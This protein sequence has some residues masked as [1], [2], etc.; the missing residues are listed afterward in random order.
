MYKPK[1]AS[2]CC[3]SDYELQE[4][5]IKQN[6]KYWKEMTSAWREEMLVEVNMDEQDERKAQAEEEKKL[7]RRERERILRLNARTI[8]RYKAVVPAREWEDTVKMIRE[9]AEK[10]KDEWAGKEGHIQELRK[11]SK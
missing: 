7:E 9:R 10:D 8:K 3:Q 2:F 6:E 11:A 5:L 1:T 4:H